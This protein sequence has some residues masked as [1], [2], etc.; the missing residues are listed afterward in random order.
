MESQSPG[1]TLAL[2]ERLGHHLVG[3][4]A[5]GL[6]GPLGAGKTQLVKGIA[7]G[8]GAADS[9]EVTSPTFTLIQ[10][11]SGRLKLYHIDAYR[12]R[13]DAELLALGLDELVRPDS[14][15]IIEW[16]DRV[17]DVL[18]PPRMVLEIE[19]VELESRR[20]KIAAFGGAAVEC[21][22]AIR[23]QSH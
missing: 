7:V 9:R 10:E 21:A 5:I 23:H 13:S 22:N 18:A 20:F 11:Y 17:I 1:E 2:G 19:S 4:L 16:A 15:V 6:V 8:N 3:G 12:L 14:V